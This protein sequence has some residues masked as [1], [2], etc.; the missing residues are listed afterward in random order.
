MISSWGSPVIRMSKFHDEF[1]K[2][3]SL[4]QLKTYKQAL[5]VH[6]FNGNPEIPM[7]MV[8]TTYSTPDQDTIDY[9]EHEGVK[10]I[11]FPS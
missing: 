10:V 4:R 3:G 5:Q 7:N 9:L 2:T 6:A 11:T 8:I 1:F